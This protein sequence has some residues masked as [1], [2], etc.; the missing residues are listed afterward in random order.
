M[1]KTTMKKA[2]QKA[3]NVI[4]IKVHEKMKADKDRNLSTLDLIKS[5]LEQRPPDGFTVDEMRKRIKILDKI[6]ASGEGSTV[7]EFDDQ[8]FALISQLTKTFKWGLL[9]KFI[10]EFADSLN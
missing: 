8:E 4:P 5:V 3:K 6:E 1:S 10:I 7:I 2:E 9:D